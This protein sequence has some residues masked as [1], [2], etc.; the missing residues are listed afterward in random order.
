MELLNQKGQ[1]AMHLYVHKDK[2]TGKG[3]GMGNY[4]KLSHLHTLDGDMEGNQ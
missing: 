2:T 3:N 1:E 4:G